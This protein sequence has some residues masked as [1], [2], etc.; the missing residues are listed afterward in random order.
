MQPEQAYGVAQF[1]LRNMENEQNTT[2]RILAAVPSERAD[3]RPDP[4]SKNAFELA[5]HL[6]SSEQFFAMMILEGGMPSPP[7]RPDDVKTPADVVRHYDEVVVPFKD[8]LKSVTAD[9]YAKT[10]DFRGLF[11]APAVAYLTIMMHHSAH[12]RGQLSVYLRPMG[13]KVPSIYGPSGDEE[14]AARA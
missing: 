6:A 9:Q 8:K 5:W 11:V 4:K 7:A 12:H 14:I 3:Y 2:R 13:A 10:I 1:L